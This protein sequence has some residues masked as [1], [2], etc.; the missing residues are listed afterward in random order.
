MKRIRYEYKNAPIPGGGY[1]TG[2]LFD[3]TRPDVLFCRTDIGGTYRF[4]A[5]TEQWKSLID[6]VTPERPNETCPIAIAL[7]EEQVG[8]FYTVCGVGRETGTCAIS[9]DYGENSIYKEI[10][11]AH[12]RYSD[13]QGLRTY[14]ILP[15]RK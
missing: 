14:F 1:V 13:L 8:T 7:Y 11:W 2:F 5:K 4:D 6:H 15:V 3:K 12:Q 9:R 10:H